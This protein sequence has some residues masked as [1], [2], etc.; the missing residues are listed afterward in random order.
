MNWNLDVVGI[1]LLMLGVILGFK[2]RKMKFDRTNQYGIEKFSSYIAKLLSKTK[3]GLFV[4]SSI[5]FSCV[6]ILLLAI[7]HQDS[8]GWIIILPICAI[9]LFVL[10]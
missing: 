5:F 2:F 4:G 8:W 1:L 7:Q 9:L 3:D 10:L 6:G